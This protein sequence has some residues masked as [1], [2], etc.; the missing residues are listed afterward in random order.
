MRT[1]NTNTIVKNQV[2]IIIKFTSRL[3]NAVTILES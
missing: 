2:V 1:T 3:E